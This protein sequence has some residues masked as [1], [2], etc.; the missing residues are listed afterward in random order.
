MKHYY[1]IV[2]TVM[3]LAH[4]NYAYAYLDPGTHSYFFQLFIAS[5]LGALFSIKLFWRTLLGRFQACIQR[6]KRTPPSDSTDPTLGQPT[7]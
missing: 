6:F 1:W 3:L 5:L 7:E 4:E 2:P